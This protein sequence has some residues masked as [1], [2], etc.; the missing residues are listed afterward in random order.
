MSEE[1]IQI[2]NSELN[3][4]FSLYIRPERL[5]AFYQFLLRERHADRQPDPV[6]GI[7]WA[8]SLGLDAIFAKRPKKFPSNDIM[9]W[10]AFGVTATPE[11]TKAEV[12]YA[13]ERFATVHPPDV[14]EDA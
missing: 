3:R 4:N 7:S 12:E 9:I 14:A 10:L 6:P 11:V 5:H 1:Q 13:L 2:F 8:A